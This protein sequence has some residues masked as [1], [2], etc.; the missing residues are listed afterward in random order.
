MATWNAGVLTLFPDMFPG[1]LGLSL[2]GKALEKGVW[3]LAVHDIREFATDRHRTVDDTPFG[4]GPGM[5]MRPDVVSNALEAASKGVAD[6]TPMIYFSPRGRLL[7]QTL[8]RELADGPGALMVC[9]RYEGLD[10]RV[11]D[12]AGLTEVSIGDY[13]LSGGEIAALVALD[14]VVRLLPGVMG[15]EEAHE[16]D[17]FGDGLLEHPLYTQPREWEGMEVPDVLTSGDHGAIAE[18]RHKQAEETTRIR[19]P[20]LWQAR[21]NGQKGD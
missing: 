7:D 16:Q 20:D 9:G 19:R 12:R 3:S 11:I 2:A 13:V 14:A 15:N 4:G 6:G 21:Q 8:V 5:V 17:S 10:Q 18:W 1:P